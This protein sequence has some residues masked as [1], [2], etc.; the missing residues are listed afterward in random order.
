MGV[1]SE[2]KHVIYT[3]ERI[4]P[5]LRTPAVVVNETCAGKSRFLGSGL[6]WVAVEVITGRLTTFFFVPAPAARKGEDGSRLSRHSSGGFE[7][8]A[9]TLR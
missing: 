4:V 5:D 1:E 3:P 2:G 6:R 9:F 8:L 7:F